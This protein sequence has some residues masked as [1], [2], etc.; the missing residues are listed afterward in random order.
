MEQPVLHDF[1]GAFTAET[2][3]TLSGYLSHLPEK[4]RLVVWAA[5]KNSCTEESAVD[6]AYALAE[7]FPDTLEFKLRPRKP[8]YDFYPVMGIMGLDERGKDVDYGLRFIGL[9]A[10]YH[11]NTLV[12]AIQAV[13]FRA[14]TME[15][16]TRILLSRLP[17]DTDLA[18]QLYTIP[19]DEEGVL[20]GTLLA[21]L[22]VFSPRIRTWIVLVNDFPELVNRYSVYN[23]PH[24]VVNER[25]HLQGV[26]GEEQLVAQLGRILKAESNSHTTPL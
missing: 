17:S 5:E 11:I 10:W 3:A 19:E 25:H 13:S 1:Q 16:K 7:R 8:N 22:T 26:Y 4:V 24:T 12:G 23:F 15:A 14:S 9:P 18:I 2:W 21:N 20:M 6:L